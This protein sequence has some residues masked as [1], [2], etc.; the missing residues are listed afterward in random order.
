M[1]TASYHQF[2]DGWYPT[3]RNME[4]F[5]D[6]YAPD[7]SQRSQITASPNQA[8]VDQVRGLPPT[9]VFVDEA[10]VLRD[11]GEAYAGKLRAAGVTVT[12]GPNR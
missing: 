12:T 3:R 4:W 7:K 9:L 6:A 10:D 1:D 11:Q 2:A 8:T 5:W